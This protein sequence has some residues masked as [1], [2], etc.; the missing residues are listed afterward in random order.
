MHGFRPSD[1]VP[2]AQVSHV[3][4]V[5]KKLSPVVVIE[6]AGTVRARF[7]KVNNP[8][9]GDHVIVGGWFTAAPGAMWKSTL[10]SGKPCPETGAAYQ[11]FT[12]HAFQPG[13]NRTGE[14]YD[15]PATLRPVPRW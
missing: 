14:K 12:S 7:S 11:Q 13:W 6:S 5:R 9:S 10:L 4:G 1:T 3:P 8:S 2:S 15:S